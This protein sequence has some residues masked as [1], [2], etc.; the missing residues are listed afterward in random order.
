MATDLVHEESPQDEISIGED[1]LR[2]PKPTGGASRTATMKVARVAAMPA[3]A[4]ATITAPSGGSVGS[5]DSDHNIGNGKV[6]TEK[7]GDGKDDGDS[8]TCLDA[9]GSQGRRFEVA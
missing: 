9:C 7:D 2:R 5:A 8:V 3:I 4:S 1:A 6:E